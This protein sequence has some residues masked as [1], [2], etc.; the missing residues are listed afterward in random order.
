MRI[1]Y[2]EPSLLF[3]SF[4]AKLKLKIVFHRVFTLQSIDGFDACIVPINTVKEGY[5]YLSLVPEKNRKLIVFFTPLCKYRMIAMVFP[6]MPILTEY[7]DYAVICEIVRVCKEGVKDITKREKQVL[8]CFLEGKSI[9]SICSELGISANTYYMHKKN[10]LK[11]LGFS[12]PQQLYLWGVWK[13][14]L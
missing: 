13:S 6:F 10:M 2:F 8:Y 9:P 14:I 4:L 7:D 1:A 12:S 11:R 3:E 5:E